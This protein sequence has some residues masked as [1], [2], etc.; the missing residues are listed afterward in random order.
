[1]TLAQH[2]RRI[3][4]EICKE[5]GCKKDAHNC[6]SYAYIAKDMDLLDI[7]YPDYFRGSSAPYAAVMLPWTGTQAEL[8]EEVAEQCA[9]ME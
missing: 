3:S 2:I 4:K 5:N 1:M 6:E 9:D 7:C 8:E